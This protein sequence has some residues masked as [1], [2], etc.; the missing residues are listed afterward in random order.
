MN[1][2][3]TPVNARDDDRYTGTKHSFCASM[4]LVLVLESYVIQ[5]IGV[6]LGHQGQ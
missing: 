4:F 3:F 5:I 2:M 6:H 1:F